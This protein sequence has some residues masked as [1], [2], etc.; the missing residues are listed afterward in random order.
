MMSILGLVCLRWRRRSL[1]LVSMGCSV[2]SAQHGSCRSRAVASRGRG[3]DRA[4][5]ASTA[6]KGNRRHDQRRQYTLTR[7]HP[8]AERDAARHKGLFTRS[9]GRRSHEAVCCTRE[10]ILEATG[11]VRE[12]DGASIAVDLIGRRSRICGAAGILPSW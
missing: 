11:P 10:V 6:I 3:A 1:D 5:G 9:L 2:A 12:L 4:A 8:G 7:G